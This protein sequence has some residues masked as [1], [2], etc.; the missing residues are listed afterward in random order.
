MAMKRII[1]HW[2]AGTYN[3][4]ALDRSHY[5]FIIDGD[6]RIITGN[7]TVEAN[8]S[9][10]DGV[11]AQHT[12]GCNTGSIGVS[13]AAMGGAQEQPFKAGRW[14]LK[15]EQWERA[16]ECVATLCREHGIAVT[17][18]TVLSHAEVEQT[19]G[20]KQRGKWDVA[21]LP[22]DLSV[23]GALAC[24]D[25]FR[26]LV[27][28]KMARARPQMLLEAKPLLSHRRVQSMIASLG[29]ASGILGMFTGF[30]WRALAV[31]AAFA[32]VMAVLFWWFY[33]HEFKAGIFK[34]PAE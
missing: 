10:R 31:M 3:A 13:M 8:E 2:T 34:A 5:H 17:R 16:A 26:A 1:L 32:L 23:K 28:S 22:W 33:R 30:D 18:Q 19:L 15:R 27:K 24:G 21:V 6:G 29:G 20:I 25:Q 12:Q 11:Y 14:P 9:T 4:S 7:H